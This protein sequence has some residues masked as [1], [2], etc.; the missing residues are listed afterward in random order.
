MLIILFAIVSVIGSYS[1]LWI[2]DY[3]QLFAKNDISYIG[4]LDNFEVPCHESARGKGICRHEYRIPQKMLSN[5]QSNYSIGVGSILVATEIFCGS[6]SEPI[7]VYDDPSNPGRSYDAYNSYLTVPINTA[8]RDGIVIR[9]WSTVHSLRHGVVGGRMVIGKDLYVNVIKRTTEF[10]TKDIR[11]LAL[12]III[13]AYLVNLSS[14][15]LSKVDHSVDP[16]DPWLLAWAGFLIVSAGLLQLAVPIYEQGFFSRL[17][18]FFSFAAHLG[19]L[20]FA[21]NDLHAKKR[22]KLVMKTSTISLCVWLGALTLSFAP[23]MTAFFGYI[24]LIPALFSLVYGIANRSMTIA[25]YSGILSLASLKLLNVPYTPLSHVTAFYVSMVALGRSLELL[26]RSRH[27]LDSI[28]VGRQLVAN[29]TDQ[30]ELN[31]SLQAVAAQLNIGRITLIELGKNQDCTITS[32]EKNNQ[33][34]TSDSFARASIPA[35]AAHVISTKTPIWHLKEGSKQHLLIG[36]TGSQN[37]KYAGTIFSVIPIID[38]E[39]VCSVI[40]FTNYS[41]QLRNLE[42]SQELRVSTIEILHSSLVEACRKREYYNAVNGN[43]MHQEMVDRFSKLAQSIHEGNNHDQKSIIQCCLQIALS[44]IGTSGIMGKIDSKTYKMEIIGISGYDDALT[45]QFLNGSIFASPDNL[46][47]PIPLAYHTGKIIILPNIN[48]VAHVMN[49]VSLKILRDNNT[50]SVAAVPIHNAV[51][52]LSAASGT[53]TM[54]FGILWIEQRK[55]DEL[56]LAHQGQLERIQGE[57]TRILKIFDDEIRLRQAKTAM[58]SMMPK[59]AA[60]MMMAGKIPRD[61]DRGYLVVLD[62]KSSSTI[63]NKI[64]TEGWTSFVS[65]D[66]LPEIQEIAAQHNITLHQVIWDA[67]YFS[68]SSESPE[69]GSFDLAVNFAAKLIEASKKWY[70]ARQFESFVGDGFDQEVARACISFG[71]ISRGLTPSPS[72]TWSIVG[73]AMAIVSKL[74]QAIKGCEGDIYALKKDIPKSNKLTEN[75]VPTGKVI[76]AVKDEAFGISVKNARGN[77]TTEAG[78]ATRDSTNFVA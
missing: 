41:D 2:P 59:W 30:N 34:I 45:N 27:L 22:S 28:E 20:S 46:Q 43:A 38:A 75:W 40:A 8:C 36:N 26:K 68:I 49:K 52:E 15:R 66:I 24:F 54:P 21:I 32:I 12:L 1:P 6:G 65:E 55:G 58:S 25:V 53:K 29:C 44:A 64:G 78:M 63:A 76:D 9:A 42:K 35:V 61:P 5:I 19:P 23:A 60:D 10:V 69:H 57:I 71:D 47:G 74:E 33:L 48:Q 16:M 7:A 17:S 56:S 77:F 73:N 67:F 72:P 3:V 11:V 37:R 51:A 4:D 50:G 39:K 31:S 70:A 62:L 18:G 13:F 14:S